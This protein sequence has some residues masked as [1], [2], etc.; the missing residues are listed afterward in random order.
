MTS[1]IFNKAADLDR[2]MKLMKEKIKNAN[3]K[4]KVQVLTLIPGVVV[5]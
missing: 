4:V 3:F 2:L 1:N 5:T